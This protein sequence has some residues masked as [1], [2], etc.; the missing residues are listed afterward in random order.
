[1][2]F[3]DLEGKIALVT[4]GGRGLGEGIA[5]GLARAGTDVV[6]TSRTLSEC[7]RV[8][9]QIKELGRKALVV[10]ADVRRIADIQK[11]VDAT[12]KEFGHLDILI[13]N[14]GTNV[15]KPLVEYTEQDYD[16]VLDTNLKGVFFYAQAAARVMIPQRRGKIINMASVAAFLVRPEV[17][18]CVYNTSK[19]GVVALTKAL[20]V[21]LAKYNINVNALAPGYFATPLTA[22]RLADPVIHQRTVDAIPLGRVGYPQDLVGATLFL[23]SSASDYITGVTLFIDGGRGCI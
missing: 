14:A 8:A 16:L 9:A 21:E 18:M 3:P 10:T 12:V 17:T 19:G 2:N 5:L 1:M 6:L 15:R 13:N 11:V 22:P 4:G 23:A 7:E 20:A